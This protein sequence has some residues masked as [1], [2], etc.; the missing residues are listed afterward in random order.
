[1]AKHVFM[2]VCVKTMTKKADKN[3]MKS[4]ACTEESGLM[5]GVDTFAGGSVRCGVITL[6]NAGASRMH[7]C[8]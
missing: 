7:A 5:P 3:Q 4:T 8:V 1:M 6:I 2:R